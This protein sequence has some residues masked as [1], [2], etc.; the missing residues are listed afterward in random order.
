MRQNRN[1]K[2]MWLDIVANTILLNILTND[3]MKCA[4]NKHF[5]LEKKYIFMFLDI[6]E[7]VV[8]VHKR[9][10]KIEK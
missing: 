8:I 5:K 1:R 2:I 3:M 10:K 4:Y 9:A 7:L 6:F